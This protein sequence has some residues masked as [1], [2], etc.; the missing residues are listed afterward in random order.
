MKIRFLR[1]CQVEVAV[2]T[3]PNGEPIFET[4]E[5]DAGEEV[6]VDVVDFGMTADPMPGGNG[7]M[8]NKNWPQFQLADGSVTTGIHLDDIRILEGQ[9]E[10]DQAFQE[11]LSTDKVEDAIIDAQAE[12]DQGSLQNLD[13]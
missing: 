2:D 7:F 10:F 13:R 9:E 3:D 6:E 4:D 11:A 8:P 12:E 5:Y 1:W